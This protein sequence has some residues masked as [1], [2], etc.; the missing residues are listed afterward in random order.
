MA[1]IPIV[2]KKKCIGCSSEVEDELNSPGIAT[3]CDSCSFPLERIPKNIS[4]DKMCKN[5]GQKT[6]L[7]GAFKKEGFV[8]L[9]YDCPNPDC[10][11]RRITLKV[12][13]ELVNPSSN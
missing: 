5:C 12:A 11:K 13:G 2:D 10:A 4:C 6:N 1:K 8:I 7:I 9:Y 3:I